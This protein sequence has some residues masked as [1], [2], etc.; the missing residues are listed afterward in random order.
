MTNVVTVQKKSIKII[1]IILSRKQFTK[2]LY[3]KYNHQLNKIII[4]IFNGMAVLFYIERK[5]LKY[6]K[7]ILFSAMKYM[8]EWRKIL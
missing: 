7:F 6:S 8:W 5:Y 1:I 4:F 3:T 2:Y